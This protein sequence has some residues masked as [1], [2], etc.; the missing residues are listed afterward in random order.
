MTS[1]ITCPHCNKAFTIDEV[2][3]AKIVDQV[4]NAEFDAALHERLEIADREQS[5]AVELAVAKAAAGYEREAAAK[6]AELNR[7]SEEAKSA[8]LRTQIAVQEATAAALQERDSLLQRY[9]S[10]KTEA[11]SLLASEKADAAAKLAAEK[12]AAAAEIARM[13]ADLRAAGLSKQIAV[14]EA[15]ESISH[16]RDSFKAEAERKELEKKLVET[17]LKDKYE[18]QLRDREDEIERWK[19]LKARLS[20]KM[21]GETLEQHCE[22]E[23]ERLR[24]SAFR[25]ASFGKDNDSSQGSKGDYIYRDFDEDRV[26]FVSVMFEMKNEDQ[27]SNTRRKNEDFLK[28]LDKDR[29]QKGCEYAVLVSLLE[30]ESELYNAGIVDVSHLYPK[31]YVVRPQ[32]FIPIIT[33]LRNAALST[34]QVKTEL[35]RVQEQNLDITKFEGKLQTFK[36]GFGRNYNLAQ[37]QF[38]EAIKRIDEAIKDLEKTKEALLK[39]GNNLRLANDKAEGL[40]IKGL[41]RG[42]PTMAAK[43]AAIESE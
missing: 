32:F 16:E 40:T 33:V 30:P 34:V 19:D 38:Q 13:E 7:I 23:F 1:Q 12:S 37:S 42:N 43:F 41:T 21:L 15:V 5:V 28:E 39:S 8:E 26:E 4:R 25:S 10:E 2:N 18:T 9:N 24:S 14:K 36:E 3:Y 29:N 35:L 17:S 31:M 20:T 22:I 11:A 6:T 27:T